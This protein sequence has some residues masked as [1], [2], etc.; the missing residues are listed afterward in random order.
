[1]ANFDPEMIFIVLSQLLSHPVIAGI[2]LAAILSAVMSTID[3]QLLVSSSA[4]A[5]D[6]YKGF[7]RRS[8]SDKEL[9]VVARLSVLVIALVAIWMAYSPESSVFELVSYAWAGFGA[10]FGPIIILSLFW[11][12]ITRNGAVAGMIVGAATVFLWHEA[13]GGLF[14]LYEIFP[15][16]VFNLIVTVLVSLADKEPPQE[17]QDEFEKTRDIARNS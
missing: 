15:G 1:M 4:V 12:R 6:L 2:L 9:V 10:A 16:F 8:A 14:D 11:K 5:E 7:I 13:K 17:I 3:S